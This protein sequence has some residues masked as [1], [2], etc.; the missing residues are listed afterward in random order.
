[1]NRGNWQT[2][3]HRV[4]KSQMQMSDWAHIPWIEFKES[5]NLDGKITSLAIQMSKCTAAFP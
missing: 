3:I 5:L 1:M 2:T 4:A